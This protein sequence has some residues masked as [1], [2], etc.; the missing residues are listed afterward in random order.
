MRSFI[1]NFIWD[2]RPDGRVRAKVAWDIAVIPKIEG[3]LKIFDPL[4]QSRAL[5]VK[6]LLRALSPGIEPWKSLIRH[7]VGQLQCREDGDWGQSEH[8]LFNTERVKPQW[9]S[10]WTAIRTAWDCVGLSAW[11]KS[12][13]KANL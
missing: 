1:K 7:R 13:E 4:E 9:S 3:G 10:L 8:W 11:G 5:L 6:M 12:E 2:G